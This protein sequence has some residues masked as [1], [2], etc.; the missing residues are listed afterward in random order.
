MRKDLLSVLDLDAEELESLFALADELKLSNQY[1]PLDG[2]TAALI[3]QKPSLRTRAS[4]EIGIKQLGGEVVVLPN[5]SIGIG[6]RESAADVAR[7]LSRYAQLIVARLFDHD[8]LAEIAHYASVPVVNALTDLS[9]PCQILSDMYTLRQHGK[10][11]P[12]VKVVFVGDGNNVVN[13][14]LEMAALYPM[15]FVL[16]APEGYSPDARIL[17]YALGSGTSTIEI[18]EDPGAAV[19]GADVI[20][21][22]VWTSMGQEAETAMRKKIF[23]P[24]QVDS[25]LVGQAKRDAVVMHCLPAHRGEEIT[26]EVLE[27]AQSI[28]FD[29]AENRLHMQKALLA[30]LIDSWR[31]DAMQETYVGSRRSS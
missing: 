12:G 29:Q 28:I 30:K 10:L 20:Y 21:T 22:D 9:H 23:A 16:A 5:E 27:G 3:F 13:S 14:W 8:V 6:T 31:T 26:H 2:I 11:R 25:K 4:F 24:Y 18:I 15:H 1:R 7:L 19:R 17:E